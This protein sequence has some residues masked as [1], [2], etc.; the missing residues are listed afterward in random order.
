MRQYFLQLTEGVT[1]GPFNIYLSGSSGETLYS[2]NVSRTQLVAGIT[3]QVPDNVPSSSVIVYNNSYGSCSNEVQI[4]F[5]TPPA[6]ITPSPSIPASVTPTP[7][8]TPTRTPT[9]TITVTVTPSIT[10]A[11]TNTPTITPSRTP[12]LS[13]GATASPTPTPTI[14]RTPSRTPSNSPSVT[15]YTYTG[16]GYGDSLYTACLDAS[17][18]RTLYSDCPP[19]SFGVDCVVFTDSGGTTPLTNKGV[20]FINGAAWLIEPDTGLI[21]L[22]SPTQC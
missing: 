15:I 5:P 20:V 17:N 22:Y 21:T 19:G 6:S 1:P 3:V 4:I 12:T 9:V 14:T 7:S 11:P 18:N 10:P 16:C 8:I 2:S 13:I